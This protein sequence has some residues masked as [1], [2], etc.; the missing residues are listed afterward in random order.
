MKTVAKIQL[1][2]FRFSLEPKAI[3]KFE[4][5]CGKYAVGPGEFD[6]LLQVI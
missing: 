1:K 2:I 3:W 4:L 6:W 5:A